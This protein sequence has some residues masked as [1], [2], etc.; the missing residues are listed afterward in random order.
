MEVKKTKIVCTIGPSTDKPGVLEDMI[1]AGMNVARFNFSHGSHEDHGKRIAAVR[2]ASR[3][4][5]IP[6]ALM[7]D[8]KGPEMR[9]GLFAEGKVLLEK[10]REFILTTRDVVGDE[11]ICSVSHKGLPKDVEVGK[12]ILLSDG[13]VTLTIT[14]VEDTDIYTIIENTG[15]MGDR[16]RVAV[17][18]MPITL[19]AV[20]EAD[21]KDLIFA[22]QQGMDYVAAS[23]IQRGSD[24]VEI[25]K[26]LEE[27]NSSIRIISK[28]ENEEGVKNIDEILRMSDGLMVARGDLGVEI[29]AEE[30]PM[31]QKLL[32]NKCNQKG[33]PVIT[34]TQM[35]DSM[36]TNPRPTRAETSDVAN[37]ILDGTDAIMLSGETANG[38]YPV[39]AVQ[40][41]A[42][43][44]EV[45]EHS[46]MYCSKQHSMEATGTTPQAISQA[47]VNVAGHLKSASII[48]ATESGSTA[49]LISKYR[50]RCPILAVTPHDDI[51]R[52][53]QLYWG[54]HAIKGEQTSNSDEM[55][56]LSMAAA[57]REG[58]I[59]EGDLIVLTAGVPSGTQ[60][61]TNMI[62]VHV[63]GDAIVKGQGIG[64]KPATGRICVADSVEQLNREFRPGDILVV[65]SVEP[66]M[67]PFAERASALI[68]AEEGYTCATAVI[69][70]NLGIPVIL[71]ATKARNV[72]ETGMIVT[73]DTVRG[74]VFEGIANA[75]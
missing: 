30:V 33:K 45:T 43:I 24:V 74:Q 35:L 56:T 67:V 10:G 69:G 58:C 8:T 61:T 41:M 71:G 65:H 32:I 14:K 57:L 4:A 15:E 37:A 6:V 2:E 44:A 25:R 9:L 27:Q 52:R 5:G 50:P 40:T 64:S 60:G 59:K 46:A 72:L 17:P 11:T 16:K 47:T 66:E 49:L 28:V 22:C 26:I 48:T 51:V 55:V 68:A 20:S 18:G 13:L 1:A 63:V 73:V 38:Q 29:P 19:P 7:L 75:R 53:L 54:V 12:Q 34:A 70:I 39:E 31:L 3:R 62:R 23:F 21:K 42:R 36:I